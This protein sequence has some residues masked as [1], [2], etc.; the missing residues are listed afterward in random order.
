M[1]NLVLSILIFQLHITYSMYYLTNFH[2]DY[3]NAHVIIG[4][5]GEQVSL[6]C[7][8]ESENNSSFIV[9]RKKKRDHSE[10]T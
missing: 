5:C 3:P 2:T 1:L 8:I 7:Q 6:P 9:N 4:N 10:I